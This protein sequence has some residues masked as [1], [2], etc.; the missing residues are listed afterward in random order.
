MIFQK[1]L[2]VKTSACFSELCLDL[3]KLEKVVFKACKT[4]DR[5]SR[6]KGN[7][8]VA[9]SPGWKQTVSMGKLCMEATYSMQ[10]GKL[11]RLSS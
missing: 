11:G 1:K 7:C 10:A 9:N 3:E 5:K 4:G 2:I 8:A 6:H